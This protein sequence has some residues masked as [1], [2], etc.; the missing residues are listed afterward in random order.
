MNYNNHSVDS[1]VSLLYRNDTSEVSKLEA[2]YIFFKHC[3]LHNKYSELD[4]FLLCLTQK[5]SLCLLLAQA[6]TRESY[7]DRYNLVN[8]EYFLSFADNSYKLYH[9]S[10]ARAVPEVSQYVLKAA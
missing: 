1:L 5:K 8:W 2:L 7:E 3:R 9:S 4:L 10:I 6:I